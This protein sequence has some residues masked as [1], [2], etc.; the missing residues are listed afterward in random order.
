LHSTSEVVDLLKAVK[1]K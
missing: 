1:T